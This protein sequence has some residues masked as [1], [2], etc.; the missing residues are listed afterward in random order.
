MR[1]ATLFLG[2]A[3][4]LALVASSRAVSAQPV[5]HD[6]SI[7]ELAVDQRTGAFTIVYA[8]PKTSLL[9]IGVT[10]GVLLISGQMNPPNFPRPPVQAIAHVYDRICG[11]V[12]YPVVG[13]Y[14]GPIMVLEGPAPVVWAGTCIIAEYIW[15]HNSFLRFELLGR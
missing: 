3:I 6:G 13:R 4:L 8:Q 11:A 2:V 10:P 1:C 9:A 7:M 15:T 12:P 14:E 5:G